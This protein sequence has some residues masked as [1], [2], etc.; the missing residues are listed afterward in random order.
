MLL[1]GG[2]ALRSDSWAACCAGLQLPSVAWW[3]SDARRLLR[4]QHC[5]EC[6]LS[7]VGQVAHGGNGRACTAAL[8]CELKGCGGW[9]S[10]AHTVSLP[11]ASHRN[12][13]LACGFS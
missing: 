10:G 3:C 8:L 1:L 5:S 9:R 7:C 4:R 12:T 2:L 6:L 11:V 13:A